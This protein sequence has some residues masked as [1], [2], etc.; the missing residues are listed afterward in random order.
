M[1]KRPRLLCSAGHLRN[2]TARELLVFTERLQAASKHIFAY[3]L[4]AKCLARPAY[5]I[6]YLFLI[7]QKPEVLPYLFN[8][9]LGSLALHLT[10]LFW[11][12]QK[13]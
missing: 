10:V 11:R 9:T 13:G 5:L 8:N 3:F 2:K 12:S 1:F 4:L 6:A 7:A